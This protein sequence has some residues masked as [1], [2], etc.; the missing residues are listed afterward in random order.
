M[1]GLNGAH[2]RDGNG[3]GW[4]PSAPVGAGASPTSPTSPTT[5][6]TPAGPS[7]TTGSNGAVPGIAGIG[8]QIATADDDDIV[9]EQRRLEAALAAAKARVVAADALVAARDEEVRAG[10]RAE[11]LAAQETLAEMERRHDAVIARLRADTEAEVARILAAAPRRVT[12]EPAAEVGA[13]APD[14]RHE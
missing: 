11:L 12:V 9:V 3:T 2:P 5:P 4:N 1:V 10:L 7:G 14:G 13:E 6:T 8:E